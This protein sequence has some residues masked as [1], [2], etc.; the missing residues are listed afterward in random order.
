MYIHGLSR[1]GVAAIVSKIRT[2]FWV[3]T[4][5]KS[6]KKIRFNCVTCRWDKNLGAQMPMKRLMSSPPFH[7]TSL[8]LFGP[9]TIKGGVI[10]TCL[11]TSAVCDLSQDYS[12][13]AFLLLL[14]RFVSIHGYPKKIFSYPGSQL[15]SASMKLKVI[16]MET[17]IEG[18]EEFWGE[19]RDGMAVQRI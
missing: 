7:S 5:P 8:D 3:V 9:L 6:V 4:L 19:S 11:C 13:C 16:E 15:V 10:F 12:A 14:R 2:K 17:F 1:L 18:S